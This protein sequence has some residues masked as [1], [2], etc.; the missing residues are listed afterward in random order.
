MLLTNVKAPGPLVYRFGTPI[1]IYTILKIY[2]LAGAKHWSLFVIGCNYF[3]QLCVQIMLFYNKKILK[4]S[5]I[6]QFDYTNFPQLVVV[7]GNYQQ[8]S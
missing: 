2:S 7:D 5:F 8:K 6:P 1:A 4:T 3:I